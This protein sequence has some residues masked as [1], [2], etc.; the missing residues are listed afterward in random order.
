MKFDLFFSDGFIRVLSN[1]YKLRTLP[2]SERLG[3]PILQSR[4]LPRKQAFILP[5]G[6]YQTSESYT[7]LGIER[8]WSLIKDF[9]VDS[10]INISLS[11][12]GELFIDNGSCTAN[13]P[14]L[15]LGLVNEDLSHCSKNHRQNIRKERNKAFRNE[16]IITTSIALEDLRE[17]YEVL[18]RQYVKDHKMVFQPFPLYVQLLSQGFAKLIVAKRGGKVLGGMLCMLDGDV[19]HYNWGARMACANVNL[20]TLLIDYAVRFA[21]AEGYRHFDFGSTPLTDD[22]LF[23]F[24]MK[25]GCENHKVYKYCSLRTIKE[26]DLNESYSPLRSLY[27]KTPV[28]IAKVAMPFV[29]PLLVR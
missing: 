25:W 11:S 6:F 18:A 23:N 3:C 1:V 12:V 28:S 4:L 26:I 7:G 17:F 15:D 24:K 8:L 10:G 20:G 13:N 19:F 5:F 16:I 21:E 9:S 27:S 22:D 14:I 2:L 29:V